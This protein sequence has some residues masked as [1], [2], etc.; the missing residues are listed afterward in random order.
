[1]R[2]NGNWG[3][4]G[5]NWKWRGGSNLNNI[6]LSSPLNVNSL[7]DKKVTIP[8]ETIIPRSTTS[9]G[10]FN[11]ISHPMQ[12]VQD[13]WQSFFKARGINTRSRYFCAFFPPPPLTP[14]PIDIICF[15][16][17]CFSTSVP[18]SSNGS[19]CS[20]RKLTFYITLSGAHTN[21]VFKAT[22]E[23]IRCLCIECQT[24]F[25]S[26]SLRQSPSKK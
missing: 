7:R 8:E 25:T 14:L 5:C 3:H 11:V 15:L 10:S 21:A 23:Y 16:F 2:Y 19:Y 13:Q 6:L 26:F 12:D 18:F 20:L 9:T 1:M 4:R 24:R 17:F 22:G